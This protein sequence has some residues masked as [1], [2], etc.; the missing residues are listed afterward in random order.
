VSGLEQIEAAGYELLFERGEGGETARF[1]G[2]VCMAYPPLPS[3]TMVNRATLVE[4]DVD[5]DA[6]EGFFAGRGV[7]F[8]I[9]VP[10]GR[11]ALERELERR[12]YEHG[13]AWMKFA[14]PAGDPAEA[15]ATDLRVAEAGPDDAEAFALVE[16]EAY[17]M[18][19]ETA[20]LFAGAPGAPDTQVFIAW[21][22]DEPAAAG[23]VYIA[24]GFAWIGVAG[25][26]PAFRRLGGQG[27]IL[28]ARID[29][30]RAQGAHTIV[31]ETGERLPDRPSNSYRNILRNGFREQYLR[32]NW[33]APA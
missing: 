31:T 15:A 12:G 2:A 4:E 7:R 17:G 28:A 25:T 26:R 10:P 8:A 20:S 21:A 33:L 14:R 1:G 6:V 29:W 19:P 24:D 13:Y 11:E 22:G 30:A 27:A 9:G 16:R 32:P 18:P 5:V 23:L 3:V